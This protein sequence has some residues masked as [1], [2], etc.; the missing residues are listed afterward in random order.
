VP[1]LI[2]G[3]LDSLRPDVQEY[4]EANDVSITKDEDQYSTDF[5]KAIKEI[6]KRAK[7]QRLTDIIII[8]SLSG[9]VDQGLGLLHELYRETNAS[10]HDNSPL[11]RL[12]LVSDSSCSFIL[13]PGT[14]TIKTS[15]QTTRGPIFSAN[16]GILPI[17]GPAT[18]ATRGCEWDV[19]DWKTEMGG[20]V[21]TSNHVFDLDKG[22]EV[23]IDHAV[24][25]TIELAVMEKAAG[26]G[27]ERRQD[28]R[29]G[30]RE[31]PSSGLHVDGRGGE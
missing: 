21:S 25:F 17:Y 16:V 5:G 3:D 2:H 4:Y 29:T 22:L 19:T 20:Q 31:I 26:G 28:D 10:R 6:L 23:E 27:G 18:I 15:S 13:Q 14:S 11:L 12:W 24:L 9:R 30:G 1:D 7:P 8:G